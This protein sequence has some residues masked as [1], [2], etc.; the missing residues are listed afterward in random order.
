MLFFPSCRNWPIW[1]LTSHVFWL[2]PP[3]KKLGQGMVVIF[4]W[5]VR[6]KYMTGHRGSTFSWPPSFS[7][8]PSRLH[9][10][11][12]IRQLCRLLVLFVS[13]VPANARLL[14]LKC[15][16]RR[17]KNFLRDL[18]LGFGGPLWAARIKDPPTYLQISL[19]IC[20]SD[21]S[22]NQIRWPSTKIYRY[23]YLWVPA[24]PNILSLWA[25]AW[26][27]QDKF[28]WGKRWEKEQGKSQ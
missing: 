14:L 11:S 20:D 15:G 3:V 9:D 19:E 25:R 21:R 26:Y 18:A 1:P 17:H 6:S 16:G 13:N 2:D 12:R 23:S 24:K 7:A 4:C 27:G 22:R 5:Q 10:W 28:C 8:A